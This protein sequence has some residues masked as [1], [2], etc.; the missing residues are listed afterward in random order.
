MPGAAPSTILFITF[1]AFG[2][3][4]RRAYRNI[5]SAVFIRRAVSYLFSF[6]N[7]TC[8]VSYTFALNPRST[9]SAGIPPRIP[10]F[11]NGCSTSKMKTSF[12]FIPIF[13]RF[14]TISPYNF[15]FVS[16]FR[17]GKTKI[18]IEMNLSVFP[19]G[20][21]QLFLLCSMIF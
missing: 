12:R 2:R 7:N 21:F 6:I 19:S 11:S 20:I 14:V 16:F 13:S 9:S 8:L 17:P 1:N 4:S 3:K 10:Q 18:S 15:F 5:F